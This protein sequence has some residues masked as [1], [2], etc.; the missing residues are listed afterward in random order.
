MCAHLIFGA[1]G[2]MNI[3]HKYVDGHRR[4][5]V[6]SVTVRVDNLPSH[7]ISVVLFLGGAGI[8]VFWVF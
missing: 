4:Q 8:V 1:K 2:A 5:F 3:H 7:L 6:I